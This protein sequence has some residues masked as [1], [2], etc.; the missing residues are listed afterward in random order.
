MCLT[1]SDIRQLEHIE[2]SCTRYCLTKV[3]HAPIIANQNMRNSF[4]VFWSNGCKQFSHK[5]YEM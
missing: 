3:G 2:Y 5:D 1:A 4:V